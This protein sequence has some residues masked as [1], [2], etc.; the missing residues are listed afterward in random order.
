MVMVC[1]VNKK[2]TAEEIE[3]FIENLIIRKIEFGKGYMVISWGCEGIGFGECTFGQDSKGN[4]VIDDEIMGLDFVRI[5][6]CKM[7]D[8]YPLLDRTTLKKASKAEKAKIVKL[9]KE[10]KA[11]WSLDND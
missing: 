10:K 6:C 1:M 3:H 11:K 7:A 2:R 5:L 4:K 8:A 9:L